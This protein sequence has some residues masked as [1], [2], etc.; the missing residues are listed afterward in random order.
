MKYSHI[1]IFFLHGKVHTIALLWDSILFL[2]H[3]VGHMMQHDDVTHKIV[4]VYESP[5]T[6]RHIDIWYSQL[7]TV[8]Y[9]QGVKYLLYSK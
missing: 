1:D 7:W 4:I 5:I 6:D 3:K 9:V 8:A 2:V